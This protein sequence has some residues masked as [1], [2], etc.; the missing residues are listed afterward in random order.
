MFGKKRPRVL[1][2]I[3]STVPTAAQM[4]AAEKLGAV[5]RNAASCGE[6]DTAEV[7]DAVCGA[8]PP[9][10]L[11]ERK[12]Q[13]HAVPQ[14]I[15]IDEVLIDRP[16]PRTAAIVAAKVAADAKAAAALKAQKVTPVVVATPETLTGTGEGTALPPVTERTPEQQ[17]QRDAEDT[18]AKSATAAQLKEALTQLN[19]PFASNTPKPALLAAYLARP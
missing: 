7:C 2:F 15:T 1:F 3:L 10:Y 11:V 13:K 19:I 5:F 4:E 16:A 8:V 6:T 18:G 9:H 14:V 17:A 12:G